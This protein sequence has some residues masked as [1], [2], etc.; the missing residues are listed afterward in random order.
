MMVPEGVKAGKISKPY[1]LRGEVN[2]ILE[3]EAGTLIETK[4]PLFI[5]IDGQRV[6]FFVEEVELVSAGQAIIKFEF[7]ESLEDA[8]KVSGLEVCFDYGVERNTKKEEG[9]L[10]NLVGMDALDKHVGALGK[11]LDY[12]ASPANPLFIIA[13]ENQELMIPANRE[14]ILEIDRSEGL[15]SFDLPE[16]LLQL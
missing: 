16:G 8:R 4:I 14:L 5:L 3:P 15:V 1:G 2:I 6:P 12:I 10:E 11:I 13:Y 7:I 9:S